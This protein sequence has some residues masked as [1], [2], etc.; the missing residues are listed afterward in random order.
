MH[1]RI[2][3]RVMWD[4]SYLINLAVTADGNFVIEQLNYM[5][6]NKMC[7]PTLNKINSCT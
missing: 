2:V 6:S 3:K 5:L 7:R 1:F 4:V